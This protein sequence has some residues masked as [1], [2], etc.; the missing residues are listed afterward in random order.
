LYDYEYEYQSIM[1]IVILLVGPTIS[2]R[3]VDPDRR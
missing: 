2:V 3:L 1:L